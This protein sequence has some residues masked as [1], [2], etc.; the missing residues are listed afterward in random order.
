MT[1]PDAVLAFKLLDTACLKVK[2]KQL[3]LTACAEF[4]SMKLALKRIFGGKTTGS[5]NGI[6]VKQDKEQRIFTK[7]RPQGREKHNA[8]FQSGQLQPLPWTNP[9]DKF[10][11]KAFMSD[12]E[13]FMTESLSSAIIDTACTSWCMVRNGWK[14]IFMTSTKIK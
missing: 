2:S 5:S 13:I 14:A 8:M 4:S 7:Q 1:L 9:L 3:A 11:T 10:S 12:T 6:Q